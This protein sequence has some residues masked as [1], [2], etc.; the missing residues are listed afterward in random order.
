VTL[1]GGSWCLNGANIGSTLTIGPGTTVIMVNSTVGSDTVATSPAG[2]AFCGNTLRGQ[3]RITG[4]TGFVLVGDTTDDACPGNTL[5]STVTLSNNTAGTELADSPRIGNQVTISGNSGTGPFPSDN[6]PEIEANKMYGGL[7]CSGN[8]P[9]ASNNG[10]PNT[11]YGT[12]SGECG[13]AGF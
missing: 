8:T 3:L 7:A 11:V 12:R 4:A 13:A 2:I 10:R 1:N 9:A 6:K 5:S